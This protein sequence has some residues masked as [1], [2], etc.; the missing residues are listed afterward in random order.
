[1]IMTYLL[2]IQTQTYVTFFENF[3]CEKRSR[4]P[5]WDVKNIQDFRVYYNI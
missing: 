1:M 2:E 3:A 5:I 4:W